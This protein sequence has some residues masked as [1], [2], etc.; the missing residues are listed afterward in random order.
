MSKKIIATGVSG[1]IGSQILEPLNE[2]GYDVYA[3]SR[4]EIAS[5][6]AKYIKCDIFNE[7]EIASV[8]N[9]V[10]PEYLIHLAWFTGENYLHSNINFD[11]INASMNLLKYFK[12]NGGTRA[13]FAG[14]CFEYDLSDASCLKEDSKLNPTTVYA[15]CKCILNELAS[16]YCQ[17]NDLAFSWGRIFYVFGKNENEKR[18]VGSLIRHLENDKEITIGS[19][20]L[21]RDYMYTR[22]IACGFTNVLESD[23][24]GDINI[25]NGKGV[26]ISDLVL[27]FA[28]QLNKEHLVRF[29]DNIGNQPPVIIGDNSKLKSIGFEPKFSLEEAINDILGDR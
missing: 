28:K 18:L 8:F 29:E 21:L 10:K 2:M 5:D 1:L 12:Q 20:K 9:S 16:L 3:L 6:T 22:D 27:A 17:S 4:S 25:C 26:L 11:Y 24:V 15:K 7:Q 23:I 14:T 19:G 13:V